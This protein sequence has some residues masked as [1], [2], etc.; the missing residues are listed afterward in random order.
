M[1]ETRAKNDFEK[2]V[3]ICITR[4][5]KRPKAI[6]YDEP[7]DFL[8]IFKTIEQQMFEN[9]RTIGREIQ[10]QLAGFLKL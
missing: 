1:L 7:T 5:W 10:N 6:L 3:K 9:S 2:L 8:A 4:E